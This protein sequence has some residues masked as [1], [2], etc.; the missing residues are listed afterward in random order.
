MTAS[1]VPIKALC[2]SACFSIFSHLWLLLICRVNKCIIVPIITYL[3]FIFRLALF[4]YNACF[5]LYTKLQFCVHGFV[6][7][8]GLVRIYKHCTCSTG[9]LLIETNH[10]NCFAFRALKAGWA[11]FSCSM[12]RV[13]VSKACSLKLSFA[14]HCTEYG[15]INQHSAFLL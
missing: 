6:L 7:D 13:Q 12:F 2:F 8:L 1:H 9:T 10:K 14:M 5:N 4:S 3:F 11:C 15:K